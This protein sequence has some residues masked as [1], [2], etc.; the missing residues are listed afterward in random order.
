MRPFA[1][2]EAHPI[3]RPLRPQGVKPSFV[4][5]DFGFAGFEFVAPCGL[6]LCGSRNEKQ[7]TENEFLHGLLS[8]V[9][10]R[11]G[12]VLGFFDLTAGCRLN[13][14]QRHPKKHEKNQG[15]GSHEFSSRGF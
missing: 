9:G 4:L 2:V 3:L 10:D 5:G 6:R 11:G 14:S 15:D 7:Q 13:L 8:L 1:G 12:L